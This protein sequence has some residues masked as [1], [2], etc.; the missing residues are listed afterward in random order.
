MKVL[1][2]GGTG[3]ISTDVTLL[4]SQREDIDLYLLN[5]GS[6]PQ[7]VPSNVKTITADINDAETVREKTRGIHFDVVADFLSYTV[8]SLNQKLDIFRGRCEQYIFIS[9]CAAYRP[10]LDFKVIT[11][12]NTDVG[13][14]LWSYGMNK[15]LCERRLAEECAPGAMCYTNVRPAYTYTYRR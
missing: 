5:R 3:I 4:A 9:S 1:L 15:T 14:P 2:I 6:L 12:D 8:D 7:F 10:P 11:E 13:N